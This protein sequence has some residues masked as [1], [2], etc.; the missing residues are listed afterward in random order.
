M[1]FKSNRT[2]VFTGILL[3]FFMSIKFCNA[4]FPYAISAKTDYSLIGIGAL[5]LTVGQVISNNVSAYSIDELENLNANQVNNFDQQTINRYS[6]TSSTLSKG[7]LLGTGMATLTLLADKS[8]RNKWATIGVM[9]MEVLM[10]TYGVSSVTKSSVLRA[11]PY[12][13]NNNVPIEIRQGI[14]ARY[15]FFSRTTAATSAMS[16]FSAKVFTDMYPNSKWKPVVWT[17]AV[18]LP[19]VSGYLK[20]D[21]GEHFTTDVMVGYTFGAVIGYLVPVLHLQKEVAKAYWHIE[22]SLNGLALRVEF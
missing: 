19:A 14:D 12:A 18:L 21:A 10:I 13:Y 17:A 22:P 1:I 8:I 4:Q 11:R 15:S 5:S 3:L 20:V 2:K 16:F 7:V 6:E 9:G